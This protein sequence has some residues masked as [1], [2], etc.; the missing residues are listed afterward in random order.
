[1]YFTMHDGMISRGSSLA[2]L[3]SG[4]CHNPTAS[5]RLQNR[6]Y[7]GF[8]LC[9]FL[10][11][12]APDPTPGS[13][14]AA[15]QYMVFIVHMDYHHR[16]LGILSPY[17]LLVQHGKTR[18]ILSPALLLWSLIQAQLPP[19]KYLKAWRLVL[20]KETIQPR[21][22]VAYRCGECTPVQLFYTSVIY[23]YNFCF[24]MS[25]VSVTCIL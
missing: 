17:N 3:C 5:I 20:L 4:C 9:L 12:G 18:W 8:L 15:L 1:M 11:C 23:S 22:V 25:T 14:E 21:D 16:V 10:I 7:S 6:L 2:V 24:V 19:L 13:R